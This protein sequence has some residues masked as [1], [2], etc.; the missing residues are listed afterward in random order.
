SVFSNLSIRNKILAVNAVN[1]L[2]LLLIAGI[3]MFSMD[4]IFSHAKMMSESRVPTMILVK[5]IQKDFLDCRLQINM[6]LHSK[7]FEK[8]DK[9]WRQQYL[10]LYEKLKTEQKTYKSRIAFAESQAAFEEFENLR[11]EYMDKINQVYSLYQQNQKDQAVEAL[12][13]TRGQF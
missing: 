2:F 8:G 6:M 3:T 7:E 12:V 5:D 11:G 4:R 9:V 13:Q 1:I 10:P